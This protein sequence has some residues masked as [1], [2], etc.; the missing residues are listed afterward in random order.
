MK[1]CPVALIKKKV[2]GR[3]KY[4]LVAALTCV[5][6]VWCIKVLRIIMFQLF[7]HKYFIRIS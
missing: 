5:T 4:V 7:F 2:D 6:V 3:L 1:I